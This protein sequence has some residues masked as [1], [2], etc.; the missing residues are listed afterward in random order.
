MRAIM[1]AAALELLAGG[2]RS[3]VVVHEYLNVA[4]AFFADGEET[5]FLGG[6]LNRLIRELRPAEA[7]PDPGA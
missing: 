4:A 7:G 6:V 2:T 5:A 3:G 1:R